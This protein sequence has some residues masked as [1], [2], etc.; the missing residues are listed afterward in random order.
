[1]QK[2]EIFSFNIQPRTEWVA[3]VLT[4]VLADAGFDSF[5]ETDDGLNAYV[6]QGKMTR[7]AVDALIASLDLT[8]TALSYSIGE[9]ENRDWNEQWEQEGFKPIVIPEL[10]RIHDDNDED[11]HHATLHASHAT[12]HDDYRYDIKLRPRMAF[13]SGSH[14][15]TSQ[16][17][18]LLL[19]Q[20]FSGKRVLD[21]GCGTGILAICMALRGAEEVVAIDID[22]FSVENTHENC[23]LNGLER[24]RVVH[25]DAQAIEGRFDCIVANI[26]RNI[27]VADMPIYVRHLNAGGQ[28]IVSGFFTSDADAVRLAAENNG[29]RLTAK[30]HKDDWAVVTLGVK[31]EEWKMKNEEWKMKN[32]K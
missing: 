4:A 11:N 16:L 27:I 32:G 14:E 21:M 24:I 10:C 12:L 8:D 6:E 15:T 3:D 23:A 30:Q 5:E 1:M 9:L 17:V 31:R 20:D 19:E 13:G 26:H 28:L 25:G 18:E 29:L 22:E 2:Y 7:E